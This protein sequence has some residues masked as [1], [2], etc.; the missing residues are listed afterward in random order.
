MEA[1]ETSQL[2]EPVVLPLKKA[3]EEIVEPDSPQLNIEYDDDEEDPKK[4]TL[5]KTS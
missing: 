4:H 3:H 1:R 5:F 2:R